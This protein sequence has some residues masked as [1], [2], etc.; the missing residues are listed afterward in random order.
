MSLLFRSNS[1][2]IGMRVMRLVLNT[3]GSDMMPTTRLGHWAWRLF[4]LCGVLWVGNFAL[5][6]WARMPVSTFTTKLSVMIAYA[7]FTL[8]LAIISGII[9]VVAKFRHHDTS[10][11]IW[12]PIGIAVLLFG[13]VVRSLWWP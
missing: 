9:A 6:A 12:M 2:S 13:A 3:G 8:T 7:Y 5:E 1:L 11:V 4:V 10:I